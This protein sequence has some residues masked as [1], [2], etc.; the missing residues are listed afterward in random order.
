[1]NRGGNRTA[2][3]SATS[4]EVFS[5][6]DSQPGCASHLG[7]QANKGVTNKDLMLKLC[8]NGS[9]I[10]KLSQ[11]VDELRDVLFSLQVDNDK[12]L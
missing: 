3:F 10:P 12:I 8:A 9:E 7:S 4:F 6:I 2:G 11:Y 1:M 5:P